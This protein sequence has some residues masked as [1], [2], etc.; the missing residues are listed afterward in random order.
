MT[1]TDAGAFYTKLEKAWGTLGL[2]VLKREP[3]VRGN[4]QHG[5]RWVIHGRHKELALSFNVD[6][7]FPGEPSCMRHDGS[8]GERGQKVATVDEMIAILKGQVE[9]LL[10]A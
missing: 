9:G 3:I 10:A 1:A 4:P 2:V 5:R 8:D 6:G 7:L